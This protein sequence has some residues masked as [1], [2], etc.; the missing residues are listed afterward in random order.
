[1]MFEGPGLIGHNV[2]RMKFGH[3][4]KILMDTLYCTIFVSFNFLTT[5]KL[6]NVKAAQNYGIISITTS[7][8]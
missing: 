6:I 3:F 1:M 7:G 2:Q 4:K 8:Y 5:E